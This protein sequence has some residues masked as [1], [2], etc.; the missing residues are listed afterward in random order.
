M[1]PTEK[2]TRIRAKCVRVLSA[3]EKEPHTLLE[4]HVASLHSTIAAIDGILANQE[5]FSECSDM[6]Q[7]ILSA[8]LDELL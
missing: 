5:T 1:T 8:W 3:N 2:L 4:T 7:R 6:E